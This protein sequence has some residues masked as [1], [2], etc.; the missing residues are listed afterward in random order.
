[1]TR[2]IAD[3]VGREQISRLLEICARL[4]GQADITH[5]LLRSMRD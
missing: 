2:E 4:S 5:W 1:M 3:I